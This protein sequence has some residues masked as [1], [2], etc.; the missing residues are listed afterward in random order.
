[1][2][3]SAKQPSPNVGEEAVPLRGSIAPKKEES[4]MTVICEE[5]GPLRL[6]TERVE[7]EA[8]EARLRLL[9]GRRSR[10]R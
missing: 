8:R 10:K 3:L 2:D 7:D 5:P 9:T 1:V 4:T 6:G